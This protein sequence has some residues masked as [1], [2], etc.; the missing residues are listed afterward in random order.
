MQT[1]LLIF[2]MINIVHQNEKTAEKGHKTEEAINTID[3]DLTRYLI[4]LSK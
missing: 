1:K 3:E 2:L 4:C